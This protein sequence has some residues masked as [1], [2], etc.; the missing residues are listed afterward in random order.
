MQKL[1]KEAENTRYEGTSGGGFV[2][3]TLSF[4]FECLD[5][6][7]DPTITTDTEL[8]EEFL[9]CAFNNAVDAVRSGR[10]RL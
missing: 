8:L 4:M 6:K 7:I 3:V 2:K 10:V 1:M 5:V 9:Q